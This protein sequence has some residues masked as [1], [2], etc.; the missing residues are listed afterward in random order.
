MDRWCC[1]S[2]A[3]HGL[4]TPPGANVSQHQARGTAGEAAAQSWRVCVVRDRR[5][6]LPPHTTVVNDVVRGTGCAEDEPQRR[7]SLSEAR[8]QQR[9]RLKFGFRLK[10]VPYYEVTVVLPSWLNEHNDGLVDRHDS[11]NKG[12]PLLLHDSLS[13]LLP[14]YI[15]QCACGKWHGCPRAAWLTAAVGLSS[16]LPSPAGEDDAALGASGHQSG[17]RKTYY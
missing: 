12:L 11:S 14:M 16:L 6:V 1:C 8:H 15:F 13:L 17:T 10:S 3:A 5:V 7:D 2:D 4:D 9:S